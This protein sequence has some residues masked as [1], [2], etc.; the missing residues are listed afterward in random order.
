MCKS[1][2]FVVWLSIVTFCGVM[3]GLARLSGS[4][5]DWANAQYT[6]PLVFPLVLILVVNRLVGPT[7]AGHRTPL[8]IRRFR[9]EPTTAQRSDHG[10][11]S[12][13]DLRVR[14]H[15]LKLFKCRS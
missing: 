7:P 12:A 4:D 13:S 14:P 10:S 5:I 15:R 9:I 8:K 3:P 6:V 1:N 2:A 11:D